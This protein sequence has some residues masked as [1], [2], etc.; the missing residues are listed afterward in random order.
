ML[1]IPIKMPKACSDCPFLIP[2]TIFGGEKGQFH[3]FLAYSLKGFGGYDEKYHDLLMFRVNEQIK[4][5]KKIN[6][7]CLL[8]KFNKQ[9]AR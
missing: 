9:K 6:K 7:D 3:C 5:V 2:D 4:N 1:K 8:V